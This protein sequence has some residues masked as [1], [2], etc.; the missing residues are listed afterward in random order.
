MKFWQL[1]IIF[2]KYFGN[3]ITKSFTSYSKGKDSE[4]L[5]TKFL[6]S[7][8]YKIIKNN[9]KTKLGEI[10]I[11]ALHHNCLII[12]EVKYRKNNEVLMHSILPRQQKRI[13]N[14]LLVF[15]NQ[16][17]QYKN[18]NIRFDAIFINTNNDIEHVI[19]AWYS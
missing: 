7:K 16:Y 17:Q 1:K 4:A 9:F 10:D 14:A 11:I 19:N 2:N 18:Y 15:L 5:A 6:K 3:I 8:K 13:Q 12:C